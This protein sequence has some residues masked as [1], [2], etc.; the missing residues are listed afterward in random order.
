MIRIEFCRC[1]EWLSRYGPYEG[2]EDDITTLTERAR[3]LY[4]MHLNR[5]ED[6][7]AVDLVPAGWS[8]ASCSGWNEAQFKHR[9][10]GGAFG[11]FDDV[12]AEDTAIIEFCFNMMKYPVSGPVDPESPAML[13]MTAPTIV[14]V[15]IRADR[16]VVWINVDGKCLLRCC[17]IKELVIVDDSLALK[18]EQQLT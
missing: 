4:M 5:L 12:C 10:G 8:R 11:T 13:D 18:K 3:E 17:R 1:D 9:F 14:E 7:P 16:E 2:R 15:H 6:L